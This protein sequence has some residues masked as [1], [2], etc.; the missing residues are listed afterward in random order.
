MFERFTGEA[1]AVVTGAVACCRTAGEPRVTDEH[2]LLA[3][4]GM[5]EGRAAFA[6]RALG[7][8]DRRDGLESALAAARRRGGM[9]AAQVRALAG[10]GVDVD[11][12]VARVEEV[13]GEGALAAPAVT[14]RP[15]FGH[16]PFT[17]EAKGVLERSLRIAV[18][19][20]DRAIGSEHL[21]LALAARPGVVAEVLADHGVTYDAV[22]RVAF[23]ARNGGAAQAG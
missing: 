15:R 13:H 3:L 7:V 17:R 4:L 1:R 21:L 5:E 12:I 16:L 14:R 2:L 19:R 9:T 23:G 20:G 10:L 22:V 8:A 6:L 11:R 18:G